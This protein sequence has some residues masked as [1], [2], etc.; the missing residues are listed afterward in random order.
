[1]KAP[2]YYLIDEIYRACTMWSSSASRTFYFGRVR[3]FSKGNYSCEVGKFGHYTI[4]HPERRRISAGA[5]DLPLNR[6]GAEATGTTTIGA[7]LT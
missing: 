4:F 2:N 1:M 5:K 3:E 6:P 7:L